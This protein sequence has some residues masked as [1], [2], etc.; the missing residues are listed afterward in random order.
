[1]S[2][3]VLM[4]FNSAEFVLLH[5][6][7][8]VRGLCAAGFQVHL[9]AP[10][11]H[12]FDELG[13]LGA[14]VHA[15]T[16][17]RKGTG[18]LA[19][20]SALGRLAM[21]YRSVRPA[22]GY[23]ETI[24]PVIYGSVAAQAVGVKRRINAISGLGSVFLSEGARAKA[25]KS[26]VSLGYRMA[27]SGH[28]VR[29]L[30]QNADDEKDLRSFGALPRNARVHRF[31]GA[32]VDLSLF[33]PSEELSQ[34]PPVVVLPARM[35]ADKGIREFA[36]ASRQLKQRGVACRMVLVGG[37]DPG[38]PTS[39]SAEHLE[40]WVCEGLVE[41]WGRRDDMPEVLRQANVVCLPSYRE[42]IPK[43]LLEAGAIG[44]AVVTTDV[45]GCR[46]VVQ[47][48]ALGLL[49]PPRDASALAAALERVLTDTAL[50]ARMAREFREHGA[51]HFDERLV[52]RKYVELFG[53]LA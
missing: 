19:E 17:D 32:G 49:V 28:D 8:V 1:M 45:P 25:L 4:V 34:N 18:L 29:V 22:I 33:P 12:R 7:A 43:V 20:G 53:E 21:I 16:L 10:P 26:L 23:H 51:R 2:A 9:A 40:R 46:D 37:L 36:E 44:R 38:N 15:W 48:G 30:L 31:G 35:L 42:G 13:A 5:R 14:G 41:W 3:R 47:G 6:V 11:G 39:L 24:K 27:L 50:R 52:V